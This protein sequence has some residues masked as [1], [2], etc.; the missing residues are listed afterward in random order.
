VADIVSYTSVDTVDGDRS[1]AV[2]LPFV[3]L[4]YR[5]H[6]RVVNFLPSQ[7]E[8]FC[9]VKKGSSEFDILSDNDH[10]DDDSEDEQ[11]V[12]SQP[13]EGGEWEWKF[14]LELEDA[15]VGAKQQK[16]RVWTLVDNQ[17]AQCLINLDASDLKQHPENLDALRQRM[18][19]LW[20]DLEEYK[21]REAA[22]MLRQRH[23]EHAPPDSSDVEDRGG[24]GGDGSRDNM[25]KERTGQQYTNRPFSCC[26]RQYGVKVPEPDESMADAGNGRRWERIY[27]LFGTKISGV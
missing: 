24:G 23:K 5:A 9:Q 7:L 2:Q 18:F 21:R 27:G 12:A 26:I 19:L 13:A 14:W 15:A 4:N 11:Q 16:G 17:T 1:F 6:V 22:K 8:D 3:N 25:I 10:S 20:G